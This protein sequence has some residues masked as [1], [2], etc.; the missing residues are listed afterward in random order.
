MTRSKLD[1]CSEVS[2]SVLKGE[3]ARRVV[4]SSKQNT[5]VSFFMLSLY[6]MDGRM[7]DYEFVFL[8]IP[9]A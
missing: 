4:L 3:A 6:S 7:R 9:P 1:R 2:L 8:T 5:I